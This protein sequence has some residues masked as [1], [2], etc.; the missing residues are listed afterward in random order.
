MDTKHRRHLANSA[1]ILTIHFCLLAPIALAQ[2]AIERSVDVA[3]HGLHVLETGTGKPSVVFEN[4]MGEDLSTWKDVQPAIARLTHTFSYD[5]AGLGKSDQSSSAHPRDAKQLAIELRTLLHA[6][7]VPG[8][9]VLVGHSLGGAIV[10]VFAFEYPDEVA[11]LVL[12]DP[13]DGRLDK[14]LSS[15]L[16]PDI[17]SARQKALAEEMPTLPEGVRREYVG[18][19][20]SGDE[21]AQASPLPSVPM[22][23][24]TGTKKNPQFPG[25]P[26]E[27]D[28]KLELHNQL[29]ARTP[30]MEHVLVPTSR[31]YIQND[32]PDKVIAAIERVLAKAGSAVRENR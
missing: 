31:H 13:G 25:N 32:A 18:L 6:A 5:R 17:W 14:L 9:Y 23:L 19:A 10:Q 1:L 2:N 12:V 27:Q 15:K 26:L 20:A 4:G 22:V 16:P 3:G 8:P 28:L 11:G 24:L 21:A 29:A 30:S 7:Q